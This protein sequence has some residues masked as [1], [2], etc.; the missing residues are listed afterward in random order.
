MPMKFRKLPADIESS[1]AVLSEVRR[2]AWLAK[3]AALS[4]ADRRKVHKA[5]RKFEKDYG[6]PPDDLDEPPTAEERLQ[7]EQC[8][9]A[10]LA[11]RTRL[12]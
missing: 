1:I 5:M 9:R 3:Y 4:P 7:D 6:D 8:I 11:H 2:K 10:M 12:N